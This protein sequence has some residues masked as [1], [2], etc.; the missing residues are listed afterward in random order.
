MVISGISVE[1]GCGSGVWAGKEGL[2][3]WERGLDNALP[4]T[5]L[6]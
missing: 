1:R 3:V 6:E 4:Q 2:F 5:S